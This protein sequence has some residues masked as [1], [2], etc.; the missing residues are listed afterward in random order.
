[1]KICVIGNSHVASLKLGWE[2]VSSDFPQAEIVFFA[3]RGGQM[4]RLRVKGGSLIAGNGRLAAQLAVTSGGISEIRPQAYDAFVIC[5]LGFYLPRLEAGV[6]RALRQ[7]AALDF[8][9]NSVLHGVFTKLRSLTEKKIWVGPAPLE[10]EYSDGAGH[11]MMDYAALADD[12]AAILSDPVSGI[13]GQPATTVQADLT[14]G[15]HY[16]DGSLRLPVRRTDAKYA[17]HP[18]GESKHMNVRFGALW[19]RANLPIVLAG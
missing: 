1:M 17:A 4:S 2:E 9:L 16:S 19:L 11:P 15:I 3:A 10:A 6:S 8:F 7:A 14:T 5:G 12:M 18:P 13:L